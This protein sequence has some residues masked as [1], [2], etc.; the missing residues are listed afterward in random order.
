[1]TKNVRWFFV[2]LISI[3]LFSFSLEGDNTKTEKLR[4]GDKA[5][6]AEVQKTKLLFGSQ[7]EKGTYTLLSFWVSYDGASRMQNAALSHAVATLPQLS[8]VSISLDQYASVYNAV[9]KQD[10]LDTHTCYRADNSESESL[11][12]NY[13]L[14]NGFATYLID[15]EG[16]IVAKNMA[17]KE[18]IAFLK[19]A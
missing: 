12:R 14:K 19:Q 3:S 5:P 8:M 6:M 11:F 9:V 1:M 15:H 16:M 2:V 18:L 4:V 10:R 7:A 13:D 17:V